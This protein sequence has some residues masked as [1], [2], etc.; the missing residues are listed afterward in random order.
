MLFDEGYYDPENVTDR[1]LLAFIFT[2][3]IQKEID[4]F[5]ETNWN[6]HRVRTQKDAQEIPI[7]YMLFQ[8]LMVLKN[9]VCAS[10]SCDN[11]FNW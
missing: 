2:P 5:R 7:T 11:A 4:I 1:H 10:H 3:V 9:V 8:K 6:S